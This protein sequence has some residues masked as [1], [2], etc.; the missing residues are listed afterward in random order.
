MRVLVGLSGW[1]DSA[2]TAHL[3]LQQGYEVIAGFMN[4]F[5]DEE[6]PECHTKQDRETALEVAKHLGIA[7]FMTFDFRE[8]YHERVIQYIYDGY[9]AWITPNPDVLCNSEI[10]FKLF[11]EEAINLWCDYV[12]TGHYAKILYDQWWYKLQKWADTS[13]DQ[14]YFLSWLDQFQLSKSLFPL[15]E[16]NKSEVRDIAHT[17]Q[18]PNADRKDS[19]W[20]CFIGKVPIKDFLKEAL[21]IK[22][23]DIIDIDWKLLWWH[24]WA[25]FYTIWQRTGLGLWWWPWYVIQKDTTTNVLTVSKDQAKDLMQSFLTAK[26]V[27]RT[28]WNTPEIPRKGHAKIRYRQEDQ[29]CTISEISKE[30]VKVEFENPQRAIS[31]GQIIV[32]YNGDNVVGNGVIE[33]NV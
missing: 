13:K 6:N 24:E 31:P 9:E 3:L 26:N 23:W 28:S 10:K 30:S 15:G 17:I 5:S 32:F 1:V 29:A 25:H 11:L 19:Q 33:K 27:H 8:Q 22:H 14:S 2:I 12:A 21:P 20:L 18:L 4:N 16:L 7:S